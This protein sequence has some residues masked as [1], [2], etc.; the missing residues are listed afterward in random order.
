MQIFVGRLEVELDAASGVQGELDH[1]LQESG[2]HGTISLPADAEDPALIGFQG[3]PRSL[4]RVRKLGTGVSAEVADA[5][6]P[7]IHICC[8]PVCGHRARL[9]G[10]LPEVPVL[11]E[12]AVEGAGMKEYGQIPVSMFRP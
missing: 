4:E 9:R 5:G 2:M 12:E 8:Q 11:A 7:L 6:S 1:F 10:L 3:K